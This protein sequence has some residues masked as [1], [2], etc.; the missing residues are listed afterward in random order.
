MVAVIISKSCHLTWN[1]SLHV[2][3]TLDVPELFNVMGML[4]SYFSITLSVRYE[5]LIPL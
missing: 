2:D 5:R 3:N 4:L 1:P